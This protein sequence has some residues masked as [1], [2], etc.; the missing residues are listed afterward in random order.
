MTYTIVGVIGHIDHG[1]TS[2]VAALTGVDTDTHP[3]EKRRGITI[4]LGF[5]SYRDGE[6]Q[7]ALIDAPGHQ[8]YI[9]NMLAGVSA[10]DIG[11]LVVAADQGIQA[12]TLEHAAILQ[13]LGARTLIAVISRMDLSTPSA[14]QELSEELDLFLADYGFQDVPKVA[15]STVTGQGLDELREQLRR[16]ARTEARVAFGRFRMPIDRVFTVEGRGCIV[17]GTPWSGEVAVGDHLQLARNGLD[18]RIRGLEVHGQSVDHSRAGFRTAMNLAGVS[19]AE[20]E[21]GDELV[22]VGAY[23]P[24][25]RLVVL[26]RMFNDASE[27]RC[28]AVV[29]MHSA[30]ASCSARIVGTKRLTP[31]EERVVVID[32]DPPVIA[33]FRQACLFRR[34]Y[35][36]GSF[37]GGR[38]LASVD[39]PD[40]RTAPLVQLGQRLATGDPAERL[41]A[42]TDFRGEWSV[43]PDWAEEQLGIRHEDIASLRASL[44]QKGL[45]KQIANRL[46]A[47]RV[48]DA[49]RAMLLKV[50]AE[51]AN[52]GDDAWMDEESLI[53]RVAGSLSPDVVKQVLEQLIQQNTIV[54]VNRLVAIASEQTVLT[55]KQRAN[56]DRLLSLFRDSR[57]PPTLKEVTE[58][59]ELA[60]DAAAS[61]VRFAVQQRLLV[62]LGNGFLVSEKFGRVCSRN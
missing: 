37:A 11:L 4:D 15:I 41:Q 48:E 34:P 14:I 29:Q 27:L 17:A 16:H 36:V 28:P 38:V 50:L 35:P 40:R 44:I 22:A 61:L 55:K 19:S 21:R 9:G 1:K 53:R 33:T 24:S 26:L 54:R 5:A 30:T 62:D 10:V 3:E 39:S 49:S 47:P 20:I 8:K 51:H 23:R 42:W 32:V 52:R 45:V 7:F 46:I 12:Q 57:T 13:S 18:V 6:H 58:S 31:G 25:S 60:K 59:L 2:L 43:D 56:M